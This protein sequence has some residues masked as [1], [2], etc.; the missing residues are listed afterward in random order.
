MAASIALPPSRSTCA[1]TSDAIRCGVA[2]TPLVTQELS[3]RYELDRTR[4]N[5]EKCGKKSN[6]LAVDV[7]ANLHG[8]CDRDPLAV[9][10]LD[11]GVAL[12]KV[13]ALP[14]VVHSPHRF[15]LA[16]VLDQDHV[17]HPVG[18]RRR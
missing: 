13:L 18:G 6:R 3:R 16:R 15:D 10:Q 9:E 11:L 1:P 14:E 12:V 5:L 7:K 8:R 2:M 17:E 4:L